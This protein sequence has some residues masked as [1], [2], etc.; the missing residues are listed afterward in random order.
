MSPWLIAIFVFVAYKYIKSK[1]PQAFAGTSTWFKPE[2]YAVILN[3]GSVV[4]GVWYLTTFNSVGRFACVAAS[5]AASLYIVFT[6][7]GLPRLSRQS[8]RA[9]LQEWFSKCMSGMEFPFLFFTLMFVNEHG[10]LLPFGLANYVSVL[11]IVRRAVWFLGATWSKAPSPLWLKLGH[12]LWLGIKSRESFILHAC[13]VLEVLMGFWYVF[14]VVTPNRQLMTM[15]VY[16]TYLRIRYMAPRSRS[17]HLAAWTTI[18]AWVAPV[19]R[20]VPLLEKPIEWGVAWF[21]QGV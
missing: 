4:C 8:I 12:S 19:R 14:L 20:A 10:S 6:N 1:R 3:V 9:P 13:S 5:A 2:N 18:G 21:N 15:F 16:W 17:A 11:L 7:Y